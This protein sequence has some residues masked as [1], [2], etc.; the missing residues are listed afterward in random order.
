MYAV[1][2]EVK[3]QGAAGQCCSLQEGGP[4]ISDTVKMAGGTNAWR[5]SCLTPNT[6]VCMFLDVAPKGQAVAEDNQLLYLQFLTEYEHPSGQRRLRVSSQPF[7]IENC[8]I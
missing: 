6:T 7:R 1:T 5:L 2:Q 8:T 3:I 4:S